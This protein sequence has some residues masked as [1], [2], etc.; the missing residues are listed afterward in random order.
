[1]VTTAEQITGQ[2]T[3]NGMPSFKETF[4]AANRA[5]TKQF[6][7][8]LIDAFDLINRNWSGAA[9]VYAELSGDKAPVAEIVLII[10]RWREAE[11]SPG[12][13]D[14]PLSCQERP[15]GVPALQS[16]QSP[17]QFGRRPR[18][19]AEAGRLGANLPCMG[20]RGA[21]IAIHEYGGRGAFVWTTEEWIAHPQYAHAARLPL[22]EII[23]IGDAQAEPLSPAPLPLDGAR[24]LDLTR[25]I[26]GPA[27]ARTL[28][29]HGAD[30]LKVP[31]SDLP[32]PGLLN[33]DSGVG[34]SAT[35]L[36]CRDPGQAELWPG[37]VVATLS[38]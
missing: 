10:H 8:A 19:R 31:R 25:V 16:P 28:A 1:M 2:S 33:I 7:K 11:T 32:H 30:V 23:R 4:Y 27:C 26:A 37:V 13:H 38:V 9:A 29:E 12:G 35:Y 22:V 20:R 3:S 18:D 36:D 5:A 14:R 24:V 21:E 17:R 15:L 34:K 6:I